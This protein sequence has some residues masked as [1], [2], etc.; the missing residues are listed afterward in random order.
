MKNHLLGKSKRK[1]HLQVLILGSR[2]IY[3]KITVRMS[4]SP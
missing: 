3:S 4:R 2:K 1:N